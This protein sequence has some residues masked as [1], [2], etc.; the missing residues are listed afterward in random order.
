MANISQAEVVNRLT[1]VKGTEINDRAIFTNT[2]FTGIDFSNLQ[3][4]GAKFPINT[5]FTNCLF[6]KSHLRGT[7][8]VGGSVNNGTIFNN[9]IFEDINNF[10]TNFYNASQVFIDCSFYSATFINCDMSNS[11]FIGC[12]IDG[13]LMRDCDF[14][15]CT[16]L[17]C[18]ISGHSGYQRIF[19]TKFFN[20]VFKSTDA[21]SLTTTC[22]IP[23][24]SFYNCDMEGVSFLDIDSA[25]NGTT[26]TGLSFFDCNLRRSTFKFRQQFPNP[27]AQPTT[28][29]FSFA[30]CSIGNA[31]IPWENPL[32]TIHIR[33][34][35]NFFDDTEHAIQFDRNVIP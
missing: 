8:F 13:S 12:I 4:S 31:V 14:S 20:C 24:S 5:D 9:S 22:F 15:N 28:D 2:D 3:L 6:K 35:I 1:S 34:S 16:F 29:R 25:G 26:D 19:R 7:F 21:N 32:N 30:R 17:D 10:S 23:N 33:V 11:I 27:P 18:Q